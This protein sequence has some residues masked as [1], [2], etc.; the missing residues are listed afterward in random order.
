MPGDSPEVRKT[1]LDYDRKNSHSLVL[2]PGTTKTN[3]LELGK[4]VSLM[5][6]WTSPPVIKPGESFKMTLKGTDVG[7]QP[8][9]GQLTCNPQLFGVTPAGEWERLGP[10]PGKITVAPRAGEPVVT[11]EYEFLVPTRDR[12]FQSLVLNFE[13]SS[14][15]YP[16][17]LHIFYEWKDR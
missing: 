7:S 15:F 10:S 8:G 1:Y 9:V 17:G 13:A 14:A 4:R 5:I 2:Q 11:N 6:T 3:Y 16:R 12:K